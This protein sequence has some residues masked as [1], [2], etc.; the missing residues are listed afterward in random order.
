MNGQM[1]SYKSYLESLKDTPGPVN[2]PTDRSIDLH[3][4]YD[5]LQSSGRK[6]SELT[7]EDYK[8]FII[9]LN[10]ETVS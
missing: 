9:W 3:K 6:A 7:D 4:L 10:K 8:P 1:K 2:P 5:Y